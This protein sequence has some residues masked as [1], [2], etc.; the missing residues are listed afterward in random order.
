MGV[1]VGGCTHALILLKDEPDQMLTPDF[2]KGCFE[3]ICCITQ[4]LLIT[5]GS[6]FHTSGAYRWFDPPQRSRSEFALLN[7]F[8][9]FDQYMV[10]DPWM[11]VCSSTIRVFRIN[12]N[13][14][15]F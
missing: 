15:S 3:N 2:V 14:H 4:T 10:P 11:P 13:M 7:L 6:C 5:L 8:M 1:G 12:F 9:Y